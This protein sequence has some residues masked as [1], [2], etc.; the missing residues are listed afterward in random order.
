MPKDNYSC[1]FQKPKVVYC[2]YRPSN[3]SSHSESSGAKTRQTKHEAKYVDFLMLSGTAF[4]EAI[5][6]INFVM[7]MPS[8]PIRAT[9]CIFFW[10]GEGGW[11]GM[12]GGGVVGG[13]VGGRGEPV[14][15]WI[16]SRDFFHKVLAIIIAEDS[17]MFFL[18]L[19]LLQ[20]RRYR[21]F[22]PLVSYTNV[23]AGCGRPWRAFLEQFW[24]RWFTALCI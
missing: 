17:R 14:I 10:G 18:W 3:I 13:M 4:S 11:G 7:K 12:G 21:N 5:R 19:L 6:A 20:C 16:C 15:G 24:L 1:I 9:I 22:E 2:L 23:H 8:W